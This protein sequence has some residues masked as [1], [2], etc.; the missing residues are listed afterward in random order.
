MFSNFLARGKEEKIQKDLIARIHHRL[1]RA[2]G[3]IPLE[4]Y[5]KLPITTV[6]SLLDMIAEEEREI[7]SQR[8]RG[9]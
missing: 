9:K 2:Y 3:W 5:E 8:K 1:M 4:E 7:E 6:F